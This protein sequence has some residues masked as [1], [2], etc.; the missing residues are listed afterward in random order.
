MRKSG[1]VQSGDIAPQ[2]PRPQPLD[3]KPYSLNPKSQ[4]LKPRSSNPSPN[5]KNLR[6][7]EPLSFQQ[8]LGGVAQRLDRE[9]IRL[10]RFEGFR[11]RV[12]GLRGLGFGVQGTKLQLLAPLHFVGNEGPDPNGRP[13]KII[14]VILIP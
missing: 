2:N 11:F 14:H 1:Q 4:T 6:Q 8:N 13:L 10:T 3:P 7:R 12:E 9:G 5:P